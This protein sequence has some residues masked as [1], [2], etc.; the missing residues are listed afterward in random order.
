MTE[1]TLHNEETS[2]VEVSGRYYLVKSQEDL[3]EILKSELRRAVDEGRLLPEDESEHFQPELLRFI[4]AG[5]DPSVKTLTALVK[6]NTL[7]L[8]NNA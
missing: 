7:I 5:V 3:Y 8:E 1:P 6:F 2:V 4:D